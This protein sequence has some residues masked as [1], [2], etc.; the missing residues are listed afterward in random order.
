MLGVPVEGFADEPRGTV[1]RHR[2]P[3]HRVVSR[4]LLVISH[5]CSVP[6]GSAVRV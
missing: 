6:A 4:E 5:R 1:P 2:I 3:G